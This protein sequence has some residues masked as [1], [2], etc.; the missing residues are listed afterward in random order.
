[1][2]PGSI[3]Q[4]AVHPSPSTLLPSSQASLTTMPSPQRDMHEPSCSCSR[5]RSGR[6][7]SSRRT[8]ARCRRRTPRRLRLSCRR[9]SCASTCS[10]CRCTST[11]ARSCRS[12]SSR[13]RR[14]GCRRRTARATRRRRRRSG[15]CGG[16]ACPGG[17]HEYP[18]S[19]VRQS[20]AQPSSPV[21]LPSSQASSWLRMPSPHSEC[22]GA[23]VMSG[24]PKSNGDGAVLV[25]PD[26]G[27]VTGGPARAGGGLR[28]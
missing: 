9:R 14:S 18:G 25:G 12:P 10:G 5:A 13:P 20:A 28:S 24:V 27:V 8:A 1:M 23:I 6:W 19:T 3:L 22:G 21:A 7:P 16:R 26:G 2:N 11:R 15:R 17:V 4:A